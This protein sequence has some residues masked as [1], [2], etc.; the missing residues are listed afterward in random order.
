SATEENVVALTPLAKVYPELEQRQQY[1]WGQQAM[2]LDR[3]P[4]TFRAFGVKIALIGSGVSAE[5]PDLKQRVRSGMDLVH[6]TDEGWAKDEVGTGTHAAGVIAG[7]DTGKGVIGIA[8]DA[9]ID[10]CKVMPDGHFSDLIAALDHCIDR[11]VD[12]AHI[13][14]AT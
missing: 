9:E 5:H 10:V 2:R 6:G 7:A 8:V 13:A 4:P 12:I 1:G 14:V 11:E 3:L